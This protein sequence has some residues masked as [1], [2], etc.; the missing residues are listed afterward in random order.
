MQL[1]KRL[2]AVGLLSCLWFA[3]CGKHERESSLFHDIDQPVRSAPLWNWYVSESVQDDQVFYQQIVLANREPTLKY[4]DA[5]HPLTKGVT[6]LLRDLDDSIRKS[7]TPSEATIPKPSVLLK[8][9]ER[10]NASVMPAP[11]CLTG[12]ATHLTA[13]EMVPEETD[14]VFLSWDGRFRDFGAQECKSVPVASD[15]LPRLAAWLNEN[16]LHCRAVVR[17]KSLSFEASCTKDAGLAKS[18]SELVVYVTGPSIVINSGLIAQFSR[19]QV[20]SILAHELAHYYRS[21]ATAATTGGPYNFFYSMD[22]KHNLPHR[23]KPDPTLEPLGEKVRAVR[24]PNRLYRR[25]AG[26]VWDSEFFRPLQSIIRTIDSLQDCSEPARCNSVCADTVAWLDQ[27]NVR[28]DLDAFPYRNLSADEATTYLAFESRATACLSKVKLSEVGN[29]T[30]ESIPASAVKD[31]LSLDHELY[32]RVFIKLKPEGSVLASL[33]QAKDT[34]ATYL[35]T[36][37]GPLKDAHDLRLGYYTVEQEADELSLEWMDEMGFLS[38][39]AISTELAYAALREQKDLAKGLGFFPFYV[40]RSR[41]EELL[42]NEWRD[43]LGKPQFVPIVDYTDPH[44]SSCFRAFNLSREALAHRNS[45][46]SNELTEALALKNLRV[47]T[48][49]YTNLRTEAE[50]LRL[51]P[52]DA[53]INYFKGLAIAPE[54]PDPNGFFG[55]QISI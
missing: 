46:K 7:F 43:E 9:D 36:L 18:F 45:Y 49:L 1:N 48:D 26:Q 50:A 37:Y 30:G 55:C 10:A 29:E 8:V 3:G 27:K 6:Q 20:L 51:D 14:K 12:F 52:S 38:G 34:L 22:A 40:P 23:P 21:H 5:D 19:E 41:C 35:K 15:D 47:T 33:R 25:V 13:E 42:K 31:A 54:V 39:H 28:K 16:L 11:I 44:H 17:G 32:T 24:I 4:V 53:R 2:G